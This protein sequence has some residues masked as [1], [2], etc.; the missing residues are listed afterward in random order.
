[1]EEGF[2]GSPAVDQ[3]TSSAV[4]QETPVH[5][6]P[7]S[8]RV[9]SDGSKKQRRKPRRSGPLT[10]QGTPRART[11]R[12][13]DGCIS[14][15]RGCRDGEGNPYYPH[16]PTSSCALCTKS[17]TECTF[18]VQVA[19]TNRWER[20]A[21]QSCYENKRTCE[22]AW[23]AKDNRSTYSCVSCLNQGITCRPRSGQNLPSSF[24]WPLSHKKPVALRSGGKP[25]GSS[26]PGTPDQPLWSADF[27]REDDNQAVATASS[28]SM[29]QPGIHSNFAGSTTA[30]LYFGIKGGDEDLQK[31]QRAASGELSAVGSGSK[32]APTT[33]WQPQIPAMHSSHLEYLANI[34]GG[35]NDSGHQT[36]AANSALP[37][38]RPSLPSEQEVGVQQPPPDDFG[39]AG[40]GN[41]WTLYAPFPE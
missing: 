5:T 25:P 7:K 33:M 40:G 32:D 37:P 24:D 11:S 29:T 16:S 27:K 8:T 23:S 19:G 17:K 38:L 28:F 13:C 30:A 18:G 2:S 14:K 15:G 1:M 4:S 12:R 21:C 34:G 9:K 41:W 35:H 6:S 3:I 10:L 31:E 20:L 39:Y 26:D 22:T 36:H